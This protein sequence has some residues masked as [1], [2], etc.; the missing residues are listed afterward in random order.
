TLEAAIRDTFGPLKARAA[1]VAP[2]DSSVP[3]YRETR[4]TVTSDPEVTSSSVQ[5]LRKRPADSD[6]LVGDY[7]RSLVESLFTRMFNDRLNEIM[8]KPDAKFLTAGVGS[9]SLSPTVDTFGL[10]ARVPDGGIAGGF[11]ALEIEARR[12][13]QFGFAASELD[14]AKRWTVASYD[15]AFNERDKNESSSYAQ[16]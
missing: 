16:E 3:L 4:T 9:D 6:L 10:S 15:R 14:R 2:P 8:R 5:L 1:A 12:V 13:Q 11:T 7:R